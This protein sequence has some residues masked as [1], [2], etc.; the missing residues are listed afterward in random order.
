M[1]FWSRLFLGVP[2]PPIAQGNRSVAPADPPVQEGSYEY[3]QAPM[4]PNNAITN[5]PVVPPAYRDNG[6]IGLPGY[7]LSGLTGGGSTA[8]PITQINAGST[9]FY[10][11]QSGM[12]IDLG[13]VA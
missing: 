7:G 5:V 2:T 9:L 10:D 13:T 1:N 3:I 8:S 4:F 12:Y 6:M 11:E